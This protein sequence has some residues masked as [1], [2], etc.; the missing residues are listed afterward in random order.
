MAVLYHSEHRPLAKQRFPTMYRFPGD[1]D[2]AEMGCEK[3]HVT[4]LWATDRAMSFE[5]AAARIKPSPRWSPN[6]LGA[7]LRLHVC[8]SGSQDAFSQTRN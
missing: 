8:P 6:A 5:D 3:V 2:T 7:L 1:T 4:F